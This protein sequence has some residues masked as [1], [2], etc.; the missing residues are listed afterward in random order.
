MASCVHTQIFHQSFSTNFCLREGKSEEQGV[1][2][3]ERGGGHRKL[4]LS[5]GLFSFKTIMIVVSCRVTLSA[6]Q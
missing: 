3:K 4:L 2:A 5:I 6:A 1:Y